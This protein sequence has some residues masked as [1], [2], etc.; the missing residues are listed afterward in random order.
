MKNIVILIQV[1]LDKYDNFSWHYLTK[2]D[3]YK[4]NPTYTTHSQVC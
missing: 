3:A 4:N 2:K 1:S